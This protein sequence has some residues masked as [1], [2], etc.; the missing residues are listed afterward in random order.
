MGCSPWGCK[1]LDATERLHFHFSLSCIGEGN[2]N[3]LVFLPRE[4]QGWGSLVGCR[5]WGRTELDMTETTQQQQQQRP[6]IICIPLTSS[7]TTAPGKL[8][9]QGLC[10]SYSLWNLSPPEDQH[11]WFPCFLRSPLKYHCLLEQKPPEREDF[12]LLATVSSIFRMVHTRAGAQIFVTCMNEKEKMGLTIRTVALVS[13]RNENGFQNYKWQ[14]Y[15]SHVIKHRIGKRSCFATVSTRTSLLAN[16]KQQQS[17]GMR[18][19]S[20]SPL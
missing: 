2:G 14:F 20:G 17:R 15:F 6:Y 7:P 5:L 8:L 9:P 19:W 3:P 4:S 18:D 12:V 10:T 1:E 16:K 11:D 13:T